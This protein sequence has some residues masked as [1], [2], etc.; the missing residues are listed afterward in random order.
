[1]NTSNLVDFSEAALASYGQFNSD[2]LP[3]AV[4]DLVN[5]NGDEH[6]FAELQAER[7][8]SR[9]SVA[10]RTFNDSTSLVG[11]G[12]SSFDVT[13]CSDELLTT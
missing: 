13:C 2:G 3:P 7:F 6:G 4:G 8:I 9:F 1:M 12:E 11:S 10:V 5:L